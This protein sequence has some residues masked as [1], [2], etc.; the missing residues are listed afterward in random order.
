MN[1]FDRYLNEVGRRLPRR[2]RDDIRDELR[3]AL[4]DALEA[5]DVDE[6]TQE[7][8]VAV[9]R[10]F[11]APKVVAASYA[12]DRY[13]IGPSLYPQ[14]VFTMRV[15]LTVLAGIVFFGFVVS[16]S[17]SDAGWGRQMASLVT[18]LLDT[19][20][21]SL[22]IVVLIFAVLQALDVHDGSTTVTE[23]W[24]PL[25]LPMVRDVD[26]VSRFDSLAG[27]V[28]PAIIVILINQFKDQIGFVLRPDD[29]GFAVGIVSDHGGVPLFNDVLLANLA[30]INASLLLP[31]ALSVWLFGMGR[32]RWTTRFLKIALDFFAVYVLRRFCLGLAAQSDQLVTA[33]LPERVAD[34]FAG[35][36]TTLPLV[37]GVVVVATSL[38][39]LYRAYK[40]LV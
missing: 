26:V 16:L 17:T 28:F 31:M 34:L 2:K 8:Q 7:D 3:S 19:V 10:E 13:L 1:L 5:R 35:L 6:P 27:I 20:I 14:F 15:V 9:L 29:G 23:P 24:D 30:W 22:G 32:W 40:S 21:M 37:I 11:G 12:G 4:D 25:D 18:Q 38:Q 36:C 39:H 33:G